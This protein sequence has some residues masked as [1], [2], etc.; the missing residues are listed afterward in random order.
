MT[1]MDRPSN[2]RGASTIGLIVAVLAMIIAPGLALGVENQTPVGFHDGNEGTVPTYECWAGGWAVDRDDL[3][4]RLEVRILV[5]GSEVVAGVADL[6]RQDL[7]DAG[8]SPDGFAGFHFDLRDLIKPLV[9][10]TVVAQA[11]D[12]ETGEWFNLNSTPR[13]LRCA[14]DPAASPFGGVWTAIDLDGSHETLTVSGG[15]ASLQVTYHDR[16]ATVCANAGAPTTQFRAHA[17][18]RLLNAVTLEVA[19][20]E[21]RCGS[22]TFPMS[23]T[24]FEY[25]ADTDQLSDG[26]HTWDRLVGG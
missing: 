25:L 17:S 11:R 18:G 22:L 2:R 3:T 12:N 15:P 23:S 14:D 6:F 10:H 19:F 24:V 5:D 1:S 8:E 26:Y 21:G 4:A 7:I 13:Q 9:W 16:F 20:D